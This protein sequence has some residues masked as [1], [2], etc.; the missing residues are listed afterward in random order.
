MAE[1]KDNTLINKIVSSNNIVDVIG[2]YINLEHKGKNFFGVCPF[3]DDHSPSMSVSP[4]KNIYKCFSC[5]ATGNSITFLM[6]YLGITFKEAIKILADN[7]GIILDS[8]FTKKKE[9]NIYEEYYK[10]NLLATSIFK[11]NLVSSKGTDA[12]EYLAK[13][14]L[15]EETIKYFDIGLSLDN[16][17]GEALSNKYSKLLLNEIDLCKEY[18]GKLVD[19]FINRIMFPIKDTDGNIVGFTGR[20]YRKNDLEESKYV[21]TKETMIFKKGLLLYNFNNALEFI[22]KQKEIIIC[23]GQMDTI[24]LYTIGIKNAV[25]LSGTSITKEQIDIIKKLKCNIVLNLDQDDAGKIATNNIGSIFEKLGL[26]VKVILFSGAKDTDELIVSS[27]KD[28]FLNAYKNKVEFINFKL[29]YLK[30]NKNL[31][32]S[33]ELSK[34]INEVLDNLNKLDDAILIELKIKELS[35]KY[36]VSESVLRSKIN[37]KESIKL[38]QKEKIKSNVY[39]KYEKA[40]LRIVYLMLEN[41]DVIRSYEN[42]LGFLVTEEITNFANE[43]VNYRMKNKGFD[44]SD[45]IT[46]TYMGKNLDTTLKKVMENGGP[47]DYTEEELDD[48][49]NMIRE[50]SV[51]REMNKLKNKLFE[52]LDI[53]EKKKI[54]KKIEN[55]K[56]EVLTWYKK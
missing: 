12:R 9:N 53:E 54:T 21:N 11:N 17:L 13:R 28:A 29:D 46:Y 56:K 1:L 45:F 49:I 18:N 7:A 43:I 5:G 37:K 51:K 8:S 35:Q 33:V 4:E 16:S 36:G 6:D 24:R 55:M 31:N 34:Y 41:V 14:S 19:T 25:S 52:T 32:D 15:S 44:L 20:I 2:N 30:K 26:K 22:R 48:L 39:N 40:E 23:E 42:N 47:S 3:H 10:I 27:G 38:I 50:Y